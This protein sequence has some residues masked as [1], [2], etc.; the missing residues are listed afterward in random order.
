MVSSLGRAL[1]L[2]LD[3]WSCSSPRMKTWGQAA[4]MTYVYSIHTS[5]TESLSLSIH[6]LLQFLSLP[7]H[8]LLDELFPSEYFH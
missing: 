5:S 6:R 4:E 7:Y 1:R 3:T 8:L 2:M